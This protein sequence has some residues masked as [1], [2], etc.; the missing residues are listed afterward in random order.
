MENLFRIFQSA[1][2][3]PAKRT[4]RIRCDLTF[5]LWIHLSQEEKHE[6][7]HVTPSMS[8]IPAQTNCARSQRKKIWST[9]SGSPHRAHSPSDGPLRLRIWSF[10]SRRPLD[11]CHRKIL[12]F[13][14]ILPFQIAGLKGEAGPCINLL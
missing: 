6:G 11:N 3:I 1:Q 8:L 12:I 2:Q 10:E 4:R 7:F 9:F 13:V 14:G 5:K